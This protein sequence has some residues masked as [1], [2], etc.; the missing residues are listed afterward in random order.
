M[1]HIY[2]KNLIT[3]ESIYSKLSL[4][5]LAGSE[6]SRVE[7]ESGEHVTELLHVLKSHSA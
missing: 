2:Y 7:E 4:V 1:I 5:D 6:S 3:G